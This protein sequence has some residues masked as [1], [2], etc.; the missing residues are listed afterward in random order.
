MH[1]AL[2]PLWR[3]CSGSG[4]WPV[5]Q[6]ASY[7]Y[8]VLPLQIHES[9]PWVKFLNGFIRSRRPGL[10]QHFSRSVWRQLEDVC[11]T[12]WKWTSVCLLKWRKVSDGS[13]TRRRV[14]W[15]QNPTE[16]I[17][18]HKDK[19]CRCCTSTKII[20]GFW[21]RP[22]N[23]NWPR[24]VLVFQPAW[25]GL[26]ASV[27]RRWN[28]RLLCQAACTQRGRCPQAAEETA[29]K[30]KMRRQL[31]RGRTRSSTADSGGFREL[32]CLQ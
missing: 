6:R 17:C 12:A 31:P 27:P 20:R 16:E 24:S 19:E 10:V 25:M 18:L 14:E 15:M 23:V 29:W 4:C 3:T 32:V 11:W 26:A 28:S 13:T 22:V 21:T 5:Q 1:A 7:S 30:E 9:W 8:Y 2:Q